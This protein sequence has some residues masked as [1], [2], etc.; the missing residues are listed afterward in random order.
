MG[1]LVQSDPQ[2]VPIFGLQR[3]RFGGMDIAIVADQ[4][5]AS[6]FFNQPVVRLS[7]GW[8]LCSTQVKSRNS[9]LWA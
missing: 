7:N 5:F 8:Y 3:Y 6:S 9:P 4:S 2:L 1:H